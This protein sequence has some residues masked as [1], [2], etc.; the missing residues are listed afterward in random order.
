MAAALFDLRL[1][2]PAAPA[3]HLVRPQT[4]ATLAPGK[5]A[6]VLELE[7]EHDVREWLSAV[8]IGEGEELT[9][10]RRAAFGGPMHVRTKSGGEFALNLALARSIVIRPTED[11][12]PGG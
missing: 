2:V 10:L 7:L 3:K 11:E 9:V 8:G 4:L 1:P 6:R 5:P 12:A